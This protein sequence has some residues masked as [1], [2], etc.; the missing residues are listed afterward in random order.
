ALAAG[1]PRGLTLLAPPGRAPRWNRALPFAP[2]FVAFS[3]DGAFVAALGREPDRGERVVVARASDGEPVTDVVIGDLPSPPSRGDERGGIELPTWPTALAPAQ[4]GAPGDFWIDNPYGVYA[5]RRGADAVAAVAGGRH[6]DAAAQEDAGLWAWGDKVLTAIVPPDRPAPPPLAPPCAAL[7]AVTD[8]GLDRVV[9]ACPNRPDRSPRLAL[10]VASTGEVLREAPYDGEIVGLGLLDADRVEV[11]AMAPSR[12]GTW[13]ADGLPW[14]ALPG[15]RGPIALSPSGAR[16]AAAGALGD[17]A[18]IEVADGRVLCDHGAARAVAVGFD[19]EDAVWLLGAEPGVQ[20]RLRVD[21]LDLA[22]CARSEGR[23]LDLGKTT[24]LL[25]RWVP[26]AR[27][28]VLDGLYARGAFGP[29]LARVRAEPAVVP[30]ARGTPMFAVG[31]GGALVALV[32]S[33][34]SSVWR[35]SGDAAPTALLAGVAADRVALCGAEL[36]TYTYRGGWTPRDAATGAPIPGRAPFLANPQPD[37]VACRGDRLVVGR[38]G[39]LHVVDIARGAI[40]RTFDLGGER[41]FEVAILPDGKR[42][43]A[44]GGPTGWRV[45]ALE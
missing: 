24:N 34:G 8:L 37:T 32:E 38:I 43:L 10:A 15:A 28:F 5:V 2:R 40:E 6:W 33:G 11:L 35:A 3:P 1:T 42:A 36:L 17:L 31:P 21:R 13:T 25:P 39:Q 22:T 26:A 30:F 41:A 12:R 20:N 9:Y 16:A 14:E 45:I 44:G 4:D 29:V 23:R 7:R 27:A 19:G 18:V